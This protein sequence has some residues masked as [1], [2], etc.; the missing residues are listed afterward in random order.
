MSDSIPFVS[1]VS[2][3]AWEVVCARHAMRA[4][5]WDGGFLWARV[6]NIAHDYRTKLEHCQEFSAS[7]LA[8]G[9]SLREG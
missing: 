9:F 8:A 6:W 3:I 4:A 5:R 1:Y 7:S 2:S